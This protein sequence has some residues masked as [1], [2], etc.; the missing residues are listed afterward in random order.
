[1]CSTPLSP[2]AASAI[3]QFSQELGRLRVPDRVSWGRGKYESPELCVERG[4]RA[5][6]IGFIIASLEKLPLP[7][8]VCT[9]I[10]FTNR[11][12]DM[13]GLRG[14]VSAVFEG[15]VFEN[16]LAHLSH[17]C[18]PVADYLKDIRREVEEKNNPHTVVAQDAHI[19]SEVFSRLEQKMRGNKN[20]DSQLDLLKHKLTTHSAIELFEEARSISPFRYWMEFSKEN[21]NSQGLADYI[22][23]MGKLRLESRSGWQYLGIRHESVAAHTFRAAQIG[24]MMAILAE[25]VQPELGTVNPHF[26]AAEVIMHENGEARVQ[27]ANLVAKSYVSPKEEQA[28]LH[29]TFN[30]GSIGTEIVAKWKAVEHRNTASGSISKDVD[31]LEMAIEAAHLINQGIP[32][33]RSWIDNTRSMMSTEIGKILFTEVERTLNH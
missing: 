15:N 23:E 33:A 22:F 19:L 30:L 17:T 27:D 13:K 5:A 7:E 26:V 16:N 3:V 11:T 25:R 14:L 29:Q 31:R 12:S 20:V 6:H 2:A 32:A 21:P 24:V 18:T 28:V 9:Q 4:F 10:L 1:M 8:R